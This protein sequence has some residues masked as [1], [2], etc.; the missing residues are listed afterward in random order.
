M[1]GMCTNDEMKTN[2]QNE[3]IT[4]LDLKVVTLFIYVYA[5][6]MKRES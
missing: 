2:K 4:I 1:W 5:T 3:T 6:Q